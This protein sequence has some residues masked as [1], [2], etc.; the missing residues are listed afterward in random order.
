[1]ARRPGLPSSSLSTA[2]NLSS[3]RLFR[4]G[5]RRRGFQESVFVAGFECGDPS[6][7]AG[8]EVR[9]VGVVAFAGHALRYVGFVTDVSG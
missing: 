8:V 2:K 9:F 4:G 1:M 5:D 3:T 6:L 7:V